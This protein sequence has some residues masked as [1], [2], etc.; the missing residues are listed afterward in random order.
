[1]KLTP[2]ERKKEILRL[3]DEQ[4]RL[5][6]DGLEAVLDTSAMTVNRD[7]RDLAAEG[8]IRRM[9]GLILPPDAPAQSNTCAL[10]RREV[11]DRSQMLMMLPTRRVITYCCPHCGLCNIEMPLPPA[12]TIFATDFLYGTLTDA[13]R[14]TF[15]IASRVDICCT[16][17]VLC[18]KQRD[19]AERF[20]QGFGGELYS[21]EEASR[22]LLKGMSES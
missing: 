7:I 22:H 19:D 15:L 1:M 8:K 16:P 18:F 4:G 9:R 17:S 20:R 11:S 21:L 10:C 12:A 5:S 2:D 6:V 14:A 3:L 13:S